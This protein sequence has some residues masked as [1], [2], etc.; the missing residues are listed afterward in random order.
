MAHCGSRVRV[1]VKVDVGRGVSVGGRVAVL[2]GNAIGVTVAGAVGEGDGVNV[3]VGARVGVEAITTCKAPQLRSNDARTDI[4]IK[5]FFVIVR[6][7]S[8]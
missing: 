6:C 4:P 2:V 8:R 7:R 1:G 3:N 5:G